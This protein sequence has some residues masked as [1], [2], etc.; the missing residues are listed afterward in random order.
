M[1]VHVHLRSPCT[2]HHARTPLGCGKKRPFPLV[3]CY[4]MRPPVVACLAASEPKHVQR[5]MLAGIIATS[6]VRSS[7]SAMTKVS[8]MKMLSGSEVKQLEVSKASI[9]GH[10]NRERASYP[11]GRLL[12]HRRHFIPCSLRL[13]PVLAES[14]HRDTERSWSS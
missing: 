14:S 7:A 13:Q 9:S 1:T 2:P 3:Q 5:A 11:N 4:R 12:W 6:L 8:C 10:G